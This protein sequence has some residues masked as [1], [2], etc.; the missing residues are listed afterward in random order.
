MTAV[1]ER[2]DT[3]VVDD[4]DR[5]RFLEAAGVAALG[6]GLAGCAGPAP[7]AG[8]GPATAAGFPVTV[9]GRFGPT[10]VPAPPRR[11]LALG[12]GPDADPS[13]R[14]CCGRTGC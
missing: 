7:A 13:G 5:R 12:Y 2:S 8:S 4:L 14:G 1:L 3:R 10:M 9:Q 6:I 11:V